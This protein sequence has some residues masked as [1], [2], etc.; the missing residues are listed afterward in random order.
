M[1]AV[2]GLQDVCEEVVRK[3]E[4]EMVSEYFK[5]LRKGCKPDT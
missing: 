4:I 3:R 2:I 5:I 1:I